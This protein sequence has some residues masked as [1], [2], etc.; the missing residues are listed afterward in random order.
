MINLVVNDVTTRLDNFKP[1][2][3]LD[4]FASFLD[5]IFDGLISAF[6]GSSGDFDFF[7][8][9]VAHSKCQYSLGELSAQALD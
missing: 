5:R 4:T 3:V 9:V 6:R 8:N 2:Q 1:T 7:I